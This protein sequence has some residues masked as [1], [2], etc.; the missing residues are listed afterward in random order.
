MTTSPAVT[1]LMPVRD[2]AAFLDQAIQSIRTQT[3]ADFELIVIDDGSTDATA[4]MLERHA[5]EDA[6]LRVLRQPKA[7]L[8][9]AL[10]RGLDVATAPLVARM[11]AD[12]VAEP[13][14]LARQVE[15]LAA[16]SR[17]AV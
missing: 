6:R 4:A 5:A 15:F 3:F 8:V 16:R 11:D 14:R 9:K 1:V 12:D 2:G 10:N 17:V 13:H 7:G